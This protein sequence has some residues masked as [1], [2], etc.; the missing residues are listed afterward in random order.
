[1]DILLPC[2]INRALALRI[3]AYGYFGILIAAKGRNMNCTEILLAKVLW[4]LGEGLLVGLCSFG[5]F[6]LLYT[7][8][9]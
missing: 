1:V 4:K 7:I 3:G 9:G 8:I 5:A 2:C 6:W